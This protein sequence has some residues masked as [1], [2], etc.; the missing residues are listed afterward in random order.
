MLNILIILSST[1]T[2]GTR[3]SA[4]TGDEVANSIQAAELDKNDVPEETDGSLHTSVL[5]AKTSWF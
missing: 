5:G 2:L 4:N 1:G 3:A